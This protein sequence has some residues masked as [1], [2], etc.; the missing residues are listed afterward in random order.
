MRLRLIY[1]ITPNQINANVWLTFT[2]FIIFL[3]H[4]IKSNSKGD[5][6]ENS[7]NSNHRE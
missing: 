2:K 3:S 1:A 7:D 5:N 6:S 4:S